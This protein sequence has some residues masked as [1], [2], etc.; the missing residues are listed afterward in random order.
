MTRLARYTWKAVVLAAFAFFALVAY[1]LIAVRGTFAPSRPAAEAGG[2]TVL[3]GAPG[4]RVAG[5]VY[6]SGAPTSA[7]PLVVVLHGDAPYV[8]PSYQYYFG[9]H[10]ADALPGTRVAALLRPGYADP[11]GDKSDGDRGFAVGENYTRQNIDRLA[12]AIQSLKSEW[13][14]PGVVVVGHSGGA[15]LA[16]DIAALNPGLVKHVF[17]VSCPCDVPAFRRH[18]ARL[19]WSPLWLVPVRSLSPMQILDQVN[20]S[21]TITAISGSDDLIALPQYAQTYIAKAK[22]LGI[23]AEMIVLRGKGHEILNETVVVERIAAA[24]RSDP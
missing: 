13:Q 8:N 3:V 1:E 23:P 15:T 21:T 20:K 10:L 12:S 4:Q 14:N 18:M 16:A 6:I 5:R 2:T 9:S 11:Y 19:Q 22:T 7:T 24:V 17:L